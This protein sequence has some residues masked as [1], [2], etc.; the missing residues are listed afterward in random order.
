MDRPYRFEYRPEFAAGQRRHGISDDDLTKFILD[1][2]RAPRQLKDAHALHLPQT[3]VPMWSA[4]LTTRAG[5]FLVT[6]SI[7][8]G[9]LKSCYGHP[10]DLRDTYNCTQPIPRVV[11]RMLGPH[12]ETY[13]RT[14]QVAKK[15]RR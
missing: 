6:F 5:R 4:K 10:C 7:C 8:D 14:E 2:I 1:L 13:R 15:F 9:A 3:S 12:D 11:F